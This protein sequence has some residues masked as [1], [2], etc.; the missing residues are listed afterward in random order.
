MISSAPHSPGVYQMFGAD[1]ALLY[2]GKAKDLSKR[3]K[4]YVDPGR[5]EYHK[6]VMRRQV[7][8]VEWQTAPTESD[9]LVQEQHLIKTL[10]P[11]YNII[12]K[13]GKMYPFLAL[14]NDKFPRLYKFR[15]QIVRRRDVFGPFPFIGD[16]NET[17]KLVQKVAKLRTCTNAC[18]DARRRPC[19]LG[20]IGYCGAP[21][22]G[23]DP[24][25]K[26]H[27][28]LA[29]QI[30]RGH[31]RKVV[32]GLA[33]KMGAASDALDYESAAKYKAQI[34]ALKSTVQ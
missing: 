9:A 30:L 5:L 33:R 8:R 1:G 13:D 23:P 16:L 17:I 24:D 15:G 31:I 3:L 29:R 4:Q 25:Y 6:I 18:M 12:L 10:R 28:R 21:C 7:A 32:A 20:Q 26:D 14:S 22:M 34:E 2:V 11:K 19:M 27:V